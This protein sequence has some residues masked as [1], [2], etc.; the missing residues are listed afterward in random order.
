MNRNR[1]VYVGDFFVEHILGGGELNDDELLKLLRDKNEIIKIRSHL[2][3]LKFLKTQQQ[4]GF[5]ISNFINLK[6]ACKKYLMDKCRYIIYEHDH[7]YLVNRNPALYE[8]YI[9]PPELLINVEFYRKAQKVFC[10]SSFHQKI[11]EDNLKINNVFNV[12]GNL[13]DPEALDL[14]KILSSK[15]KRDCYSVLNSPTL[16]KN[17]RNTVFYCE[18][19]KYNYSLI[20]SS[21]YQEFLSLMSNNDKFIFMPKTPETLSRVV[22]EARMM[23]IKTITS[24]NIGAVH[25]PWFKLK[26]QDLIK[27]MLNKRKEIP[28]KVMEI[29]DGK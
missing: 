7:K 4:S 22:V 3:N 8:N 12:S 15:K 23:G 24:N 2:V 25:E 14:M 27:I 26:G 19:K 6:Q 18:K 9:V 10:Q 28:T 16:H 21:N 29:F 20:A 1:I 17:T 5:I 11:V 13:W